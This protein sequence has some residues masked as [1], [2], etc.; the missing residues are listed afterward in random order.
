M[1]E[2]ISEKTLGKSSNASNVSEHDSLLDNIDFLALS[3]SNIT[4][5]VDDNTG[6]STSSA[7][8]FEL[9]A[10]SNSQNENVLKNLLPDNDDLIKILDIPQQHQ[11][12]VANR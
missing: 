10:L 7:S 2:T 3:Q 12:N 5:E 11:N 1:S 4:V 8:S 6:A 9:Q